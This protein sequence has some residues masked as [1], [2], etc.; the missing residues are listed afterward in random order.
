MDG[1]QPER[2]SASTR[3]ACSLCRILVDLRTAGARHGA[4]C[5]FVLLSRSVSRL[6]M[7]QVRVCMFGVEAKVV[8]EGGRSV[9]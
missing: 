6:G 7:V 4:V 5:W 8:I 2:V 1:R 3:G 9:F